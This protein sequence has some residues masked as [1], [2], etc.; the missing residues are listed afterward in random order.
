MWGLSS[1]KGQN[2]AALGLLLSASASLSQTPMVLKPV[3]GQAAFDRLEQ[4]PAVSGGAI[5]GVMLIGPAHGKRNY[6]WLRC[7]GTCSGRFQIQ[8]K[9]ADAGWK[10]M[11]VVNGGTTPLPSRVWV[12][13]ALPMSADPA[14]A[15]IRN[16]LPDESIAVIARP[17][18][19]ANVGIGQTRLLAG[20][21][22]RP[23]T[24]PKGD[25]VQISLTAR[26]LVSARVGKGQTLPCQRIAER[27]PRGFTHVCRLPLSLVEQQ[28]P[29]RILI[30]KDEGGSIQQ[31][32]VP[33]G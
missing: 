8:A 32:P 16:G 20:W 11:T 1:G 22:E 24:P 25:M 5:A 3:D 10:G 15:G 2:L 21:S 13:V 28:V 12:R 6:L 9:S 29:P 23:E 33:L 4:T 31:N 30:E 7:L 17:V 27:Q 19:A 26:Q 18:D 14:I